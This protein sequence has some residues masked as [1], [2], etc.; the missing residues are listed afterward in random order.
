[1]LCGLLLSCGILE[2]H[3]SRLLS[4]YILSGRVFFRNRLLGWQL[5]RDSSVPSS[6][7]Q[8]SILRCLEHGRRG[9][10]SR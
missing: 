5:L 4:R 10:R 2:R 8:R 9:V 6:V 1:M 7:L 3:A